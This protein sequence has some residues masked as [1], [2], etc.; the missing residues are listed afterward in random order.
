LQ[1]APRRDDDN[2]P[3]RQNRGFSYLK[4]E[5]LLQEAQ[6]NYILYDLSDVNYKNV[7]HSRDGTLS[8]FK[9]PRK[10]LQFR[11]FLNMSSVR[12]LL[13]FSFR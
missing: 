11:E 7:I 8:F 10:N 9:C 5:M 6:T 12:L 2:T 13:F 1:D 3:C 4:N